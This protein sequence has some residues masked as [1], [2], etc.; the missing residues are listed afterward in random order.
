MYALK[1][2]WSEK[3]IRLARKN[4]LQSI[5]E[6]YNQAILHRFVTADL[7]PVTVDDRLSWFNEHTPDEFPVYVLE[8]DRK[9]IGWCSLSSYR[10]GRKALLRTAE[11]SCY[12]DYN[13]H[14]KGAGTELLNYVIDDCKRINKHVLFAIVL[15]KNINSMK[16]LE[17]FGFSKWGFL[18]DVADFDGVLYGHFYFGKIVD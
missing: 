3:M 6:I 16:L 5:V 4:D 12:I 9:I 14:G 1:A 8:D 18:P 7:D 2:P 11:I 15:E 13:H 17:K 10:D